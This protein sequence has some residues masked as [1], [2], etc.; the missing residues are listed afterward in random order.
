MNE[1]IS[2]LVTIVLVSWA[3]WSWRRRKKEGSF[4]SVEDM[5]GYLAGEAAKIAGEDHGTV[6]DYSEKSVMEVEKILGG[7]HEQ[8]RSAPSETG[9]KGLTMAYGA[10]LGEVIRRRS[11][12][13]RWDRNHP[14]V[15]ENS[16]PLYVSGAALF[17]CAW[18]YNRITNGPEDNVRHKYALS[19]LQEEKGK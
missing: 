11:Q 13:S 6:L 17:P 16:Y 15:G 1:L 3:L 19:A 18:C 10:Y 12:G 2:G 8:Y 4:A 9:V 7:L 5:M 14:A